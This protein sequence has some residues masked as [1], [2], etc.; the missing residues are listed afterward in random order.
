MAALLDTH[1]IAVSPK[2]FVEYFELKSLPATEELFVESIKRQSEV[3]TFEV[4]VGVPAA[5]NV[6]RLKELT[7]LLDLE[8]G[9]HVDVTGRHLAAGDGVLQ[10]HA[11]ID[12]EA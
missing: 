3:I 11:V 10:A 8:I 9:F 12:F 2:S 1:V 4:P 5:L 7:A 6:V